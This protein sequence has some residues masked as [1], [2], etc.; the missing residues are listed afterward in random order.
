MGL[1]RAE[2]GIEFGDGET[3]PVGALVNGTSAGGGG[4]GG[5]GSGGINV[6]DDGPYINFVRNG[7]HAV[8][9]MGVEARGKTVRELSRL[10]MYL[11][12]G[13]P[14]KDGG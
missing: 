8:V 3:V 2:S 14:G 11:G 4:G 9:G 10:W 1:M 5:G 7:G 13:S 6:D 12:G